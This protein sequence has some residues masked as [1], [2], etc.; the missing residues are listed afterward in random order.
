MTKAMI[1]RA[2]PTG[3]LLAGCDQTWRDEEERERV[4]AQQCSHAP[5]LASCAPMKWSCARLTASILEV[6]PKPPVRQPR[7]DGRDD[8]DHWLQKEVHLQQRQ[9]HDD[10]REERATG[11]EAGEDAQPGTSRQE[12]RRQGRQQL[13]HANEANE[14]PPRP[15]QVANGVRASH[16]VGNCQLSVISPMPPLTAW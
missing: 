13:G 7:F 12:E 3:T 15:T 8:R 10:P 1:R 11:H 5:G 2:V 16:S 6:S 14:D 9:L 4:R